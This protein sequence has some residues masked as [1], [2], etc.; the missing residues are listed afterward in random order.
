MKQVH[1]F[2][3]GRVQGVSFRAFTEAEARRLD[4]AGWVRNCPDGR[5]ELQAGGDAMAVDA[6]LSWLWT[7]SPHASVTAVNVTAFTGG[8]ELPRPFRIAA[9]ATG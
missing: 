5:V 3:E 7:G 1:V 6:L 8:G 4:L 2:V 9:D